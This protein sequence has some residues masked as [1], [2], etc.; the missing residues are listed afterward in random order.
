MTGAILFTLFGFL[1]GPT[2]LGVLSAHGDMELLKLLAELTLALVLFSDAASANV[3]VLERYRSLPIRLLLIGLPLTVLLGGLVGYLLFPN[4]GWVG[5]G[6]MAVLLA[7]TDAALGKAV[8]VSPR[9][10]H[11]VRESLNVESGLNDGICV[12]AMLFLLML[13]PQDPGGELLGQFGVLF[14]E[15]LGIGLVAGCGL[16]ALASVMIQASR[17]R[18]LVAETW[19]RLTLPALAFSCYALAQLLGGSG[20]I[21]SFAGGLLYGILDRRREEHALLPTETI[22]NGLAMYTWVTYGCMIVGHAWDAFSWQVLVYALCSLSIV[23]ILPVL[24]CLI[25]TPLRFKERLFIGWFG[26]RGLA[27]VVFGMQIYFSEHVHDQ[28]LLLTFSATVTLSVFLHGLSANPLVKR[29]Y[30]KSAAESR[31]PVASSPSP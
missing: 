7:P 13:N 22:G 10:P 9:V 27:S 3:N 8:I 30:G 6:L 23:R 26:P 5:I 24:I 21:A 12:P 1:T 2:F 20:F 4:L 14:V 15:E 28:E 31:S 18:D 17:K 19:H 29:L 16:A 11:R 25:G